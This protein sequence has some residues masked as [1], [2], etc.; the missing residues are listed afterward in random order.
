MSSVM[1]RTNK[2]KTDEFDLNQQ[3][4]RLPKKTRK[5]YTNQYSP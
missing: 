1:T 5:P 3:G 2:Q 4:E